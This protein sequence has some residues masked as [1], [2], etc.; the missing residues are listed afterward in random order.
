MIPIVEPQ[1]KLRIVSDRVL[2]GVWPENFL[3]LLVT[4]RRVVV[5]IRSLSRSWMGYRTMV[6][7]TRRRESGWEEGLRDAGGSGLWLV[8]G[9]SVVWGAGAVDESEP[10]KGP[11]IGQELDLEIFSFVFNSPNY[12]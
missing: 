1:G 4:T 2:D 8:A 3:K 5:S 9:C 7:R 10:F 12:F 6:M 11:R